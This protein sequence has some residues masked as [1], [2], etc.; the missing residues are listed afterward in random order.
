MNAGKIEQVGTPDEVF[1]NP[2]TKFVMLFL[3][4]VNQF[5][6]RLEKRKLQ[7]GAYEYEYDSLSPVKVEDNLASVFV[8]PHDLSLSLL[9]KSGFSSIRASVVKIHSAGARVRVEMQTETKDS[10]IAEISHQE[11]QDLHLAL[12]KNVFVTPHNLHVF[13]SIQDSSQSNL[14]FSVTHHDSIKYHDAVAA[15]GHECDRF[16][17]ELR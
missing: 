6:D 15:S 7:I 12:G 5:R 14:A 11:Y 8:R 1:H 9:P 10:L 3:G 17:S 2:A 13:G 4:S 16:F